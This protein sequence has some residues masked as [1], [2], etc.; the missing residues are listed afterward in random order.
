MKI[1]VTDTNVFIDL[2]QASALDLFFQCRFEICT[3]DLVLEEMSLPEQRIQIDKHIAGNRLQL[4]ELTAN[5][6]LEAYNLPTKCN[7][8]RITDKSVLLK[9][10]QLQTCLL[11]GD[12][13]LRKEGL[14]AG[15]AN[16]PAS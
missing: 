6:I 13:D 3:T 15:A 11:T 5:E 14:R 7:L 12:G 9:A 16:T 2:I 4:L 1:L 8:K 10:I